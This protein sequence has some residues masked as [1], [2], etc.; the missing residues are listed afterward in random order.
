MGKAALKAAAL[1]MTA[2]GP[3]ADLTVLLRLDFKLPSRLA[4]K[5]QVAF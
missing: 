5:D 1:V 3:L 4:A 2:A